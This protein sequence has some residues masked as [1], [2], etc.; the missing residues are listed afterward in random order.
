MG[1]L[2]AGDPDMAAGIRRRITAFED[3]VRYDG[4][5]VRKIVGAVSDDF[6]CA[7][8]IHCLNESITHSSVMTR[9][10]ALRK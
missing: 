4:E 7:F 10:D 8:I 6:A 5:S 1:G 9:S 2:T 3:I